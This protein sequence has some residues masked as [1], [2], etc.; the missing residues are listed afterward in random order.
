MPKNIPLLLTFLLSSITAF[1]GIDT[2]TGNTAPRSA[3]RNYSTLAHHLCDGLQGDEAK[4]NAVYNWITHNIKYDIKTVQKNNIKYPKV[5]KVLKTRKAVCGG[6]AVL[7][8]AMCREAGLQAVNIEGYAKDWTFDN[9][10][11]L[12]I[13]RHMWAAVQVNGNWQLTDPTWG[14]GSM[15]QWP[16]FFR[17]LLNKVTGQSISYAKRMKFRFVYKPEYFMQDPETFRLKHLPLDPAWQLTDT[18]MPMAVFEAGDSAVKSFNTMYSKPLQNG[19]Q[20]SRIAQLDEDLKLFELSD[21]AF[22]FNN[23]FKAIVALKS[24]Y[25]ATAAVQRA[26][27]DTTIST[28]ALLVIDASNSLKKSKEYIA[29]QKKG[30]PEVYSNLK[31]KNRTKNQLAGQDIRKIKTDDKRLVSMSKKYIKGTSSKFT[32]IKKKDADAKKRRSTIAPGKIDKVEPN[33]VAK[34]RDDPEL[35]AIE[36]SLMARKMRLADLKW[37]ID[38]QTVMINSFGEE[39]N[40]RLDSLLFYLIIEDSVLVK[41]AKARLSMHDNYD[42]EVLAYNS[43]FEKIKYQKTDTLYKYYCNYYDTI[44]KLRELRQKTYSQCMDIHKNNLRSL[45]K[46]RKMNGNAT[47][48]P[49]Q[50]AQCITDYRNSLDSF[51]VNNAKHAAYVK[52]N[53]AFFA[54]IAKLNKRQLTIAMYMEK[55]EK[56]RKRLE[57]RSIAAD[58]AMDLK[59]NEKQKKTVDDLLKKVNKIIAEMG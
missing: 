48:I 40:I 11:K 5:A 13:P 38:S 50:Y 21:R 17:R 33:R 9:G 4:A 45:E 35:L 15:V 58:Q 8:T 54:A 56:M 23:R 57:D 26:F 14:A 51:Y 37:Q 29:E 28:G 12:Y 39:N 7:F 47:D 20:Q 36:D 41:Q 30:F 24:M 42:D 1:A 49:T 10:D 16:G 3:S 52:K 59:E 19:A 25:Q 46:Y 34:K 43:L 18:V 44:N 27:T 31:K 55:A 53:K 22:A 6:Y 2:L 32:S